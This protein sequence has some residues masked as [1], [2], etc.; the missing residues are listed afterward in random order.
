MTAPQLPFPRPDV[1]SIGPLYAQLRATAP[2]CAVRTPA[3]D[4]AW[5][6]TSHALTRELLADPRL[7]RSHPHPERAARISGSAV[8]GGPMGDAATEAEGHARMRKLLA[9]AFAARRMHRLRAHVA[10]LVAEALDG[11]AAHG[12]PADLHELVSLPIPVL[13]ICELLGVPYADRDRFRALSEGAGGLTDRDASL[14]ALHDLIAYIGELL[15]GKRSAPGEDVLSD[16]VAADPEGRHDDA[17]AGLAA[18]L[19]F[20]GHETTVTRIDVGTV[21]LLTH[22]EH[23]RALAA[24]PTHVAAPWRR[25][26]GSPRPA[27]AAVGCPATRTPTSRSGTSRSGRATPSCSPPRP[28]T[29][30]RRRSPTPRRSTPTGPRVATSRSATARATAS[31]PRSP[32]SSC[33]RCS[34]RCPPASRRWSWPCPSRSWRCAPTCSPVGC[35]RSRSAGDAPPRQTGR[36]YAEL[37]RRVHGP[38]LTPGA[39]GFDDELAGFQTG[40]PHR[41]DVVVGAEDAA[42]VAA[43]VTF[44]AE[45]GLPVAVHAT[46]HG[47]AAGIDGGVVISTHRMAGVRVYPDTGVAHIGAGAR[48]AQ[49]AEAAAEHGLAPLSG[50]FPAVGAVGYLLGG[51]LG[52]LGRRYGWAADHVRAIDLVTADGVA[53][54]ATADTEPELFWALRGGREP[55]AVVTAVEVALFAVPQVVGGGLFFAA[56]DA[57]QVLPAVRAIGAEAPDELGVSLGAIDIPDLP[58]VPAPLRGRQ[59]LHVRLVD[60]TREGKAATDAAER[61]GAAGEVLLGGIRAMPYPESGSIFAEPEVPHAYRGTNVLVTELDDAM[62]AAVVAGAGTAAVPC[63]VDV[64]RLGGALGRAPE[65]PDAV[66]FRDAAW[67]VRVLSSTDGHRAEAVDAQ[68]AAVLRPLDPVRRGRSAGFL[69]GPVPAAPDELHEPE[70]LAALR[71]L[72]DRVDPDGRFGAMSRIAK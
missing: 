36:M 9:P 27:G 69:Y 46:G 4:P 51:G 15:P 40:E 6:V 72:R 3:G 26:S 55:L 58:A 2:L 33:R 22:P 45:H 21:L 71:R 30:T 11:M 38:V 62:L 37:T 13:V 20:A 39:P 10:D 49:V 54:R 19:L 29:G 34:P 16:L 8:L 44:A 1:L 14:R 12:A 47:R 56:T 52:L 66:S 68:H 7:G 18:M 43:A 42:D 61:L 53:R 32:A 67:I 63:V 65:V 64:R 60:A 25:S 70:T 5:L 28:R 31:G 41:P 50:S 24:D 59:V 35:V 57:P 23:Y 17:T 48:W